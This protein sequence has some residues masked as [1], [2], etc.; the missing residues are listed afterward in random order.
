MKK[1]FA[2]IEEMTAT[3]IAELLNV[4]EEQAEA[5]RAFIQHVGGMQNARQAVEML[6]RVSKA[7]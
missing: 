7:A 4:T 3:E 6:G 2:R 5:L 1:Q